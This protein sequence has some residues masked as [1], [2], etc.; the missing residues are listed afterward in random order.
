[1]I[2]AFRVKT[3]VNVQNNQCDESLTLQIENIFLVNYF[4]SDGRDFSTAKN[5]N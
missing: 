4:L 3:C 5:Q 1:M 2:C